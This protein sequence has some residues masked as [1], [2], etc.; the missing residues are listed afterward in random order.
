MRRMK[1][2]RIVIELPESVWK[3]NKE[4]ID[5][6]GHDRF[7]QFLVN[8]L[9]GDLFLIKKD[10]ALMTLVKNYS[11]VRN[12]KHLTK[13]EKEKLAFMHTEERANTIF[14]EFGLS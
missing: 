12:I 2:K 1:T 14:E 7:E 3:Q 13:E 9:K 11:S 8:K 4:I 10:K 5:I 6:I